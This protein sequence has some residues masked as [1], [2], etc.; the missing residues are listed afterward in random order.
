[1]CSNP[2]A[3][4]NGGVQ[5]EGVYVVGAVATYSCNT[6]YQ[7]STENTTRTCQMNQMWS[8]EFI[9]CVEGI[10][11]QIFGNLCSIFMWLNHLNF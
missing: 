1:M 3:L 11:G 7:F 8:Q 4:T 6:G 5:N 2:P 10:H 9:A